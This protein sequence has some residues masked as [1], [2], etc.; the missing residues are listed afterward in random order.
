MYALQ[1]SE[2]DYLH[3][4]QKY[5]YNVVAIRH[6]SI[7]LCDTTQFSKSIVQLKPFGEL[8]TT[9]QHQMSFRELGNLG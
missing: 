5:S 4:T 2:N 6:S 9:H 7:P 1:S 3:M 8:T